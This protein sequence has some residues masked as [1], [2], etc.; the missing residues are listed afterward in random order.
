MLPDTM[1][2]RQRSVSTLKKAAI[3]S[4]V[5]PTGVSVMSRQRFSTSGVRRISAK[6]CDSLPAIAETYPEVQ[7]TSWFG[8]VAPPRTPPEIAGKLSQAFA[9]ILRTPE[10][11]KR[12]RDM[13]LNA[14]GGTPDEIKAFFKEETERWSKVIVSGNIKPD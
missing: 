4:G 5:P 3:S 11:E 6:A 12:W 14:V 1:T 9:A 2:F 10:V 13:N 7:A 8:V